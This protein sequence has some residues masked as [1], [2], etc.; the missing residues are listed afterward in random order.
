MRDRAFECAPGM[1]TKLEQ[2]LFKVLLSKRP[3]DLLENLQLP[4][5]TYRIA[6]RPRIGQK[7]YNYSYFPHPINQYMAAHDPYTNCHF[8]YRIGT[9]VPA[10]YLLVAIY[11]SRSYNTHLY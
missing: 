10:P 5:T 11:L 9:S 2:S 4:A 8:C 1:A 3:A 7:L 6:D